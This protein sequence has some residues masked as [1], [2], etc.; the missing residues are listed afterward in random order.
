MKGFGVEAFFA[1]LFRVHCFFGFDVVV[2][3]HTC[4]DSSISH[5]G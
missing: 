3:R 4:T 5:R 1:A 2:R